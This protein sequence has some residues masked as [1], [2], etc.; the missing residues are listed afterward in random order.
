MISY[1]YL[2][3]LSSPKTHYKSSLHK[4]LILIIFLSITWSKLDICLVCLL[5]SRHLATV[6][7]FLLTIL[8]IAPNINLWTVKETLKHKIVMHAK[9]FVSS[10]IKVTIL[11]VTQNVENCLIIVLLQRK[12]ANANSA[13]KDIILIKILNVKS[14]LTTVSKLTRTLIVLNVKMGITWMIRRDA[15]NYPIIV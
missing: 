12:T 1:H 7:G 4:F 6:S 5:F 14:Y 13:I 9:K 8:I 10:A 15:K 11:I 3:K 2:N